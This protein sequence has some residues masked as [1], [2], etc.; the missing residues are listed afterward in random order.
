M[1]Q[2]G[3]HNISVAQDRDQGVVTLAGKVAADGDKAKADSIANSMAA[4]QV[5]SDEIAV[6]PPGAESDARTVNTDLDK[7]IDKN[8]DA[9]LIQS[10]LPKGVPY[11]VKNGVVTLKG[12]VSSGSKRGSNRAQV[13]KV[14]STVPNVRQV[15]NEVEVR[16]KKLVHEMNGNVGLLEFQVHLCALVEVNPQHLFGPTGESPRHRLT[17][18]VRL[19]YDLD[20]QKVVSWL[21]LHGVNFVALNMMEH[22]QTFL[23]SSFQ[24]VGI[25]Q[26]VIYPYG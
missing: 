15:V 14:T 23:V 12:N 25:A 24:S 7:A 16:D 1:D 26:L 3:L 19:G 11:D 20:A 8:V 18:G 21:N 22:Y 5:V 10:G 6:L 4:G 2:A 17:G 9:A 13:E